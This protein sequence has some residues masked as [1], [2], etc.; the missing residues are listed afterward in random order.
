MAVTADVL[1]R[2]RLEALRD[3]VL[4][5]YGRIDILVNAAGGNVAAA[6][7]PPGGDVFDLPEDAMR[8]VVD[9]NLLGTVLPTQLLGA[10][11]A[12]GGSGS[13]VNITSM[14]AER[15]IT[16][17]VGY[18]AAKAAVE[19]YTRWMATELARRFGSALRVNA[20]SPGF[21][22]ADQN[23]ALLTNEDGSLTERGQRIIDL[24]PAGRF[25]EPEEL[26][27]TLVWLC[28]DGARFVTGAVVPVDGG[29]SAFSG[30]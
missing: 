22:L 9:L 12:A 1:D 28:G 4:N 16:R 30:V 6:T 18:S 26:I 23:R 24:T 17:V 29:F 13:I 7:L 2:A 27:G 21:F 5:E 10:E 8:Q 20:I 15:A 25:G 3:S 14:A 11:L 19:N